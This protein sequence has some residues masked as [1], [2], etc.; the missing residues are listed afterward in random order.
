MV[1]PENLRRKADEIDTN[2]TT[3][4]AAY[5]ALASFKQMIEA[6][7][8]SID[9][10]AS[11]NGDLEDKVQDLKDQVAEAADVLTHAVV[12]LEA[13]RQLVAVGR[14]GEALHVF[15]RVLQEIDP[16]CERLIVV[17]PGNGL[18]VAGGF[19]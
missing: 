2:P 14:T 15:D 4:E 6:C 19:L 11:E 12:D 16:K 18:P 9:E 5:E 17:V 7:A 13:I 8:E 10:L 1:D 3:L